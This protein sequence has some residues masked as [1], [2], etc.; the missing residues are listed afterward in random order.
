ME[1]PI[2]GVFGG[3]LSVLEGAARAAGGYPPAE[4]LP[5]HL[6]VR[7]DAL[8]RV[9]LLLLFN[10]ADEEFPADCRVLFEQRAE[11]FLDAESLAMLARLL[12]RELKTA[13]RSAAAQ[14]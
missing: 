11:H 4:A 1:R 7:F 5:Y 10:D 14:V 3:R 13:I 9:P 8:P 2:T 12:A 6:A